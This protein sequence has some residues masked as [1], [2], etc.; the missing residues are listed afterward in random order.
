M[1][2]LKKLTEDQM[3]K[4]RTLIALAHVDGKLCEKEQEFILKTLND[5]QIDP[6]QVQIL[7]QDFKVAHEPIEFFER[8]KS[9]RDRGML[10][11][12]AQL[13]FFKDGDFSNYEKMYYDKFKAKHMKGLDLKSIM[14]EVSQLESATISL[15]VKG[16]SPFFNKFMGLVEKYF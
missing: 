4:W 5:R 6:A 15:D 12:L 14:S 10:F 13:M 8:I 11:Y 7:Q 3:N 9:A 1:H 2:S 16:A